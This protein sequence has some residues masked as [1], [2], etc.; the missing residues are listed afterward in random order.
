MGRPP[1]RALPALLIAILFAAACGESVSTQV[2]PI[3]RPLPEREEARYRI[4]DDDGNNIGSA[5]LTIAPE[6]DGLRLGLAYDFGAQRTDTGSV[7]VQ[8]ESMKPL[9]VERVV[10]DG[11]RRYTLTAQYGDDEVTAT[12]DDGRRP[13]ERSAE[14]SDSAYDNLEA[15]Y[16]WRT[17]DH[18]VGTELR[19]INVVIDPRRGMISRVLGTVEVIGREEIAL[20]SGRVDA[21]KIEFRSAGV[22]NVAWYRA[23]SSR[24][25]VRYEISRGP[26]LVLDSVTP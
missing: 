6:T 12:L 8:R 19:Y 16:L 23:D 22:T 25:L 2:I 13:R 11:E 15:L 3:A 4:L 14:L 5:V 10:V 7:V 1:L 18:G 24:L 20:P 26:T 17:I 21:W 9:R